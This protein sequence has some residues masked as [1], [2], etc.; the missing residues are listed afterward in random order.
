MGDWLSF[1]PL[2]FSVTIA[3]AL[4]VGLAWGADVLSWK[5]RQDGK[6]LFAFNL[7]I[8]AA[9]LPNILA[10]RALA[11]L[12]TATLFWLLLVAAVQK[13]QWKITFN[14]ALFKVLVQLSCFYLVLAGLAWLIII[15]MR[16]NDD[17]LNS[18][19]FVSA[20][21]SYAL[22]SLFRPTIYGTWNAW[23]QNSGKN[24]RVR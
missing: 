21:L 9:L 7:L 16:F 18:V 10:P 6:R 5:W 1:L 3:Q 14:T 4:G 20:L 12:L 24:R 17:T 23:R 2:I 13:C 11:L 8:L 22:L 15:K 19:G